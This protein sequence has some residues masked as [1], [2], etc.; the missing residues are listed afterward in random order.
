M[1]LGGLTR[2]MDSSQDVISPIT[3]PWATWGRAMSVES[4]PS[5]HPS[6]CLHCPDCPQVGGLLG[7]S[8]SSLQPSLPLFWAASSSTFAVARPAPWTFCPTSNNR[9]QPPGQSFGLPIICTWP[10]GC[11]RRSYSSR[12]PDPSTS[13]VLCSPLGPQ[14]PGSGKKR[15][16]GFR[17]PSLGMLEVDRGKGLGGGWYGAD[18]LKELDP[19]PCPPP[20]RGANET[21]AVAAVPGQWLCSPGQSR[22]VQ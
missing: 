2:G 13:P 10:W 15:G 14:G 19:C 22:E 18:Q 4:L 3:C 11:W 16:W 17:V 9:W 21:P 6:V 1:G 8:A 7:G 12:G 5:I 20:S